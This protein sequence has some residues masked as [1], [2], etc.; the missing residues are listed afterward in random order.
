MVQPG[1]FRQS[2][3]GIGILTLVICAGCQRQR[4]N[5]WNWLAGFGSPRIPA[6][7]N[8]TYQVSGTT[9]NTAPA[10][11]YYNPGGQPLNAMPASNNGAVPTT[12]AVYRSDGWQ[13]TGSGSLNNQQAPSNN[14]RTSQQLENRSVPPI[15]MASTND[16]SRL[17]LND[18]SNVLAPSQFQ[19]SNDFQRFGSLSSQPNPNAISIGKQ[20]SVEVIGNAQVAGSP[21]NRYAADPYRTNPPSMQYASPTAV[22]AQNYGQYVVPAA[23]MNHPTTH[24]NVLATA[25]TNT[26]TSTSGNSAN[27][28]QTTNTSNG[29]QR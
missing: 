14:D 22:P 11:A 20:G 23:H 6:P 24:S 26:A 27:G 5:G 18:A 29:F 16:T 25:T 8:G 10:D 21:S 1:I 17:P 7:A 2:V 9:P 15:T 28:W 13:P 4:T 19:A 3:I 12:P